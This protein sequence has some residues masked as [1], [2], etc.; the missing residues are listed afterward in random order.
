MEISI[1]T[2]VDKLIKYIAKEKRASIEDIA[3][4]LN[5]DPLK[6]NYWLQILSEEGYVKIEYKFTKKYAIWLL[7]HDNFEE[8]DKPR[9]SEEQIQESAK[10][11]INQ[12][13]IKNEIKEQ[14][15]MQE[16]EYGNI[17]IAGEI[18]NG[19]KIKRSQEK[20]GKGLY[21]SKEQENVG[22]VREKQEAKAGHVKEIIKE[23]E[24]QQAVLHEL[25]AKREYL[26][27]VKAKQIYNEA[28]AEVNAVI[29]S[30]LEAQKK[31]SLLKEEALH[32]L[33]LLKKITNKEN[34]LSLTELQNLI[35]GQANNIESIKNGIRDY[36]MLLKNELDSFS[37]EMKKVNGEI[38]TIKDSIQEIDK[39]IK[40]HE[41]MLAKL[42]LQFD[43]IANLMVKTSD[44]I[45]RLADEKKQMEQRLGHIVEQMDKKGGLE[46]RLKKKLDETEKVEKLI[47]DIALKY[48]N[49]VSEL[50]SSMNKYR[51]A[52][53]KEINKIAI[54]AFES[55]AEK[56]EQIEEQ[57]N[58][59]I[60][61]IEQE[62]E[63]LNA[64]IEK[65]RKK[66][67]SLLASIKKK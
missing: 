35:K 25:L 23:I 47:E 51:E 14:T 30:M 3:A 17:N 60:T 49:D 55:Y 66:I 26:E 2:D 37:E 16:K 22:K 41:R 34:R 1:N 46:E 67:K 32:S 59:K 42:S 56:L 31:L 57:L 38:K 54:K 4:H 33:D 63:M 8:E 15:K 45:S 28:E 64:E 9:I 24:K 61:D 21:R 18:K 39:A 7:E 29:D 53:E 65:T 12:E 10:Q 27:K 36:K 5:M 40:E 44:A 43:E 48:R 6:V 20:H 62:H 13:I 52:Y 19:Q 58:S 50:E 11:A